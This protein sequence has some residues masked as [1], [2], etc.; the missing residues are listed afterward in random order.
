M[1]IVTQEGFERTL[2]QMIEDLRAR[3]EPAA[4][5]L[6]QL[7]AELPAPPT[8]DAVYK[9]LYEVRTLADKI[10]NVMD[11][12]DLLVFRRRGKKK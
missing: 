12:T 8:H 9:T 11:S 1:A 3:P 2:A 6:A 5:V 10:Q 4:H 7:I